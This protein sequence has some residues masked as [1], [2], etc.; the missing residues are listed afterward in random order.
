MTQ[1]PSELA[2]DALRPDGRPRCESVFEGQRCTRLAGHEEGTGKSPNR[3]I[4]ADQMMRWTVSR[5]TGLAQKVNK[6]GATYQDEHRCDRWPHSGPHGA[7]LH[8]PEGKIPRTERRQWTGS[9][10][11][12]RS[13]TPEVDDGYRTEGEYLAMHLGG[14]HW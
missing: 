7:T 5:K 9:G 14:V 8:H 12:A 2:N 4:A 1:V 3:H 6:C 10:K 13:Y 11:D